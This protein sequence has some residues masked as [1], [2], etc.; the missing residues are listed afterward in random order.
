MLLVHHFD[1][2]QLSPLG[3]SLAKSIVE[4]PT[5]DYEQEERQRHHQ[6]PVVNLGER[7]AG[8]ACAL[9]FIGVSLLQIRVDQQGYLSQGRQEQEHANVPDDHPDKLFRAQFLVFDV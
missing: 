2:D 3:Y 8:G 4:A 6:E 1:P 7:E 9:D 5:H